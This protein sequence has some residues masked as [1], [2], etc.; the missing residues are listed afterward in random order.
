MFPKGQG[1]VRVILL[2]TIETLL[3]SKVRYRLINRASGVGA[4]GKV[5]YSLAVLMGVAFSSQVVLMLLVLGIILF[6]RIEKPLGKLGEDVVFSIYRS[7]DVAYLV[8]LRI[9]GV[10]VRVAVYVNI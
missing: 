7:I 3:G 8:L 6:C 9:T 10:G 2:S 4:I 1:A 5:D